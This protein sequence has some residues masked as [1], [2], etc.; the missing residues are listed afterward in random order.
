MSLWLRTRDEGLGRA[1]PHRIAAALVSVSGL[2]AKPEAGSIVVRDMLWVG[3]LPRR[4]EI[5]A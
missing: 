1:D 3:R 2:T 4:V 5:K